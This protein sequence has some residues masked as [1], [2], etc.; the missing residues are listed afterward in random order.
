MQVP[1]IFEQIAR[2][3]VICWETFIA[4]LERVAYF[5]LACVFVAFVV[6]MVTNVSVEVVE[7]GDQVQLQAK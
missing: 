5:S 6:Y 2:L 7:R 1:F 4:N 3:T